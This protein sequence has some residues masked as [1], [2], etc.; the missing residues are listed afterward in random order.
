MV[1]GTLLTPEVRNWVGK[2][3]EWWTPPEPVE[4]S[5]IRRFAE[6]IM[7]RNPLYM[8]DAYGKRSRY[9]T[10]IAPPTLVIRP[11]YG[12]EEARGPGERTFAIHVP[13]ARR[14][15]N[16]GNEVEIFRPVRPGDVVRQRSRVLEITEREGR[17]GRMVIIVFETVFVNQDD[18]V[19]A[20]GRQTGIRMP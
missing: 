18:K 4:R 20:I 14:G 17:S 13:G 11:P 10:R 9:G 3:S 8:D 16:A 15:V 2:K 19:L 6:A 5:E 7:D 12:G 1:Q